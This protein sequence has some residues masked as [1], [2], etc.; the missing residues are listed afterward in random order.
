M[1]SIRHTIVTSELIKVKPD[2]EFTDGNQELV[3][4][5][6]VKVGI[7]RINGEYYAV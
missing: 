4:V 1:H 2:S 3:K 5:S 7:F 6:S